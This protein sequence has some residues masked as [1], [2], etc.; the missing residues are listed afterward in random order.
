MTPTL[1]EG[2]AGLRQLAGQALG[3]SEWFEITQ[4]R[5]DRFA[6]ATLDDQWLHTDPERAKDSPFGGTIAHGYLT[7]SLLPYLLS[8]VLQVR[9]V[10][11]T[12]NYGLDKL[13]F[14]S[15]V[16]VGGRLRLR[17]EAL[18]AEEVPGGVQLRFGCAVE[19]EGTEKPAL[20]AEVLY[21]YYA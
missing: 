18:A 21:R 15:P 11:G 14:P 16:K 7:L 9:G 8:Q 6:E 13:R 19:I 1:S 2:I 4:E 20:V 5:V 12:L 10:T 17:A 3:A